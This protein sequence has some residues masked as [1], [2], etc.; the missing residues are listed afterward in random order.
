MIDMGNNTEIPN[1]VHGI[2]H[3]SACYH[4]A[5]DCILAIP[6]RYG[7]RFSS[8]CRREIKGHMGADEIRAR[9]SGKHPDTGSSC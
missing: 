8:D 2:C 4:C 6:Q 1:V 5:I 9:K 3:I 7:S